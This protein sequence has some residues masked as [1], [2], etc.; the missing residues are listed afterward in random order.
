VTGATAYLHR[1][2]VTVEYMLLPRLFGRL[3]LPVILG[4]AAALVAVPAPA[5]AAVTGTTSTTDVVLS[6]QCQDHA[7][8]YDLTISPGTAFW[9][10]EVQVFGPEGNT[11]EGTVANSASSPAPGTVHVVFC[12]SE[13]P[14]A[15]T[16]RGTGFYE[17]LPAVQIPYTLPETT[18]QVR[19]AETRTSLTTRSLRHGR[20]KAT[21][22]VEAQTP[23]GWAHA[24]GVLVRLEKQVDGQ[25]RA[26]RGT[27][28]STVRGVAKA[29]IRPGRATSLRAVSVER[30]STAG[31]TS[32]PVALR[33]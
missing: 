3:S 11:S 29:T 20:T 14:G 4:V 5:Q 26:V 22:R 33:G 27:S 17:V 9:R 30:G 28:L 19:R 16:V 25:W 21:V 8:D 31:S 24:E 10:L 1:A 2:V 7:I 23:G 13:T 32:R 12:G 18:F 15:Y 6:D